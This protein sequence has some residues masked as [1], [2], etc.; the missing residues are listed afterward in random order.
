[1]SKIVYVD[2]DGVLANFDKRILELEPATKDMTPQERSKA[3]DGIIYRKDRR[4]FKTLEPII[5]AVQGFKYLCSK[6]EVYILS[7]PM[8]NLAISYAD[9]RSWVGE[10]LGKD[11]IS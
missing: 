7:T 1:M 4:I 8:W 3:I 6:F 2:M 11:P 5:G 9:K 10:H